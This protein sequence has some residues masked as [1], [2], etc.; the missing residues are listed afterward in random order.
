M[1]YHLFEYLELH[2]NFPGAGIFQYISKKLTFFKIRSLKNGSGAGRISP[3][4]DEY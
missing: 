3:R 4:K 2:Y 1:L